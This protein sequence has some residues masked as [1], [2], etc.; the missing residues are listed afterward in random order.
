[1]RIRKSSGDFFQSMSCQHI[2]RHRRTPAADADGHNRLL[3]H[4]ELVLGELLAQLLDYAR[5]HIVHRKDI[6]VRVG[7]EALWVE[8]GAIFCGVC[9]CVHA[10]VCVR[11][12]VYVPY[13]DRKVHRAYLVC[14]NIDVAMLSAGERG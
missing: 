8:F 5:S 13:L 6:D 2:L 4:D 7:I 14:G 9:V 12:C 11:A 10:R 1:M 3:A